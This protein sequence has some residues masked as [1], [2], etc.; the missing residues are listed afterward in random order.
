SIK[1]EPSASWCAVAVA[2]FSAADNG[3]EV[4][5][6]MVF[7]SGYPFFWDNRLHNCPDYNV[8]GTAYTLFWAKFLQKLHPYLTERHLSD[9]AARLAGMQPLR[10]IREL[11]N[12][13]HRTHHV[14][15]L[16]IR[17]KSLCLRWQLR[18]RV[19]RKV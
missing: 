14:G 3:C 5:T 1:R 13:A 17:I 7:P 9:C 2:S 12:R 6:V 8:R 11:F 19:Q 15:F 4:V 10:V 16:R 18:N